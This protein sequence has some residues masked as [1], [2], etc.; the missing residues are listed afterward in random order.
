VKSPFSGKLDALS[1]IRGV[2]GALV[3][4]ESDGLV[5]DAVLQAGVRGEVI[6]AL[7]ASLYRR[8]R[9]AAGAAGLGSSGFLTLDADEGRICAA[10][11]GDLV[12]VVVA[13][14]R[15]NVGMIRMEMLRDTQSVVQR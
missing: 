6:A 2:Q 11:T 9:L 8:A 12:I 4:G 5:V 14:P 15:A 10:G 1:R 13:E 3:A 7:A